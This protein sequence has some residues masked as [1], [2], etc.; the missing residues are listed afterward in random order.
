MESTH[1]DFK[2]GEFVWG[3]TGWEEYTV[4]S[5]PEDLNKIVYTDVPLSYYLGILGM[6]IILYQ[7]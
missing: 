7:N 3:L 1:P 5:N 4:I 2:Q 6:T